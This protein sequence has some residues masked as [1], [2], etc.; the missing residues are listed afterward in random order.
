MIREPL[1]AIGQFPTTRPVAPAGNR[2]GP[3]APLATGVL[4]ITFLIS[5][6]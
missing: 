2:S 3:G 5:G 6:R 4:A 1:D